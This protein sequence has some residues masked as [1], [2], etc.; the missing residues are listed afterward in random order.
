MVQQ[1]S[2]EPEAKAQTTN[3]VLQLPHFAA[4]L[5]IDTLKMGLQTNKPTVNWKNHK[6][7]CI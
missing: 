1:S 2:L 4:S 6:L 5:H 7:K 3:K